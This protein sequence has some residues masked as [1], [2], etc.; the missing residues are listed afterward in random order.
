MEVQPSLLEVDN[1]NKRWM[2]LLK[3]LTHDWLRV[4]I[5]K[6]FYT[7]HND[8]KK[9]SIQATFTYLGVWLQKVYIPPQKKKKKKNHNCLG[10][11]LLMV[12]KKVMSVM[13]LDENQ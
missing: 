9:M 1:P 7:S 3:S 5:H 11:K 13:G 12:R 6:Y 2:S 8:Q 4:L 10:G